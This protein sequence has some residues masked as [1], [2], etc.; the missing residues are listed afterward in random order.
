VRGSPD[1]LPVQ[2]DL[3][4]LV[5]ATAANVQRLLGELGGLPVGFPRPPI[6]GR[7]EQVQELVEVVRGGQWVWLHGTGMRRLSDMC[8]YTTDSYVLL[9]GASARPRLPRRCGTT[10]W[11]PGG[12]S[13]VQRCCSWNSQR[14]TKCPCQQPV[15]LSCSKTP[16]AI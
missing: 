11:R 5:Q 12:G 8:R 10:S 14:G 2:K 6:F 13:R 4:E 16:S 9:Q 1:S 3:P 15:P 7:D